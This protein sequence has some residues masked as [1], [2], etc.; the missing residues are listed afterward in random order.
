MPLST[1]PGTSF[2]RRSLARTLLGRLLPATPSLPG[3]PHPPAPTTARQA[4]PNLPGR[5]VPTA[6]TTPGRPP[7]KSGRSVTRLL[8]PPPSPRSTALG[9][10][11]L[12]LV[13]IGLT[14]TPA[15]GTGLPRTATAGHLVVTYDDGQGHTRT[16]GLVCGRG[17]DSEGCLR[18]R[19]IGGPVGPVPSGQACSMIFGGAQTAQLTGV[20]A[21]REVSERYR[22]TNGC[23]VARWSRMVPALPS[24]ESSL[25]PRQLLG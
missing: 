10:L 12:G 18:L 23:E 8:P 5:P 1:G 9:A 17:W 3:H 13:A 24:P 19:E 4:P 14:Q 25:P 15:H 16:Y 22:R 7:G 21:G 2:V 20:W 11:L 6:P